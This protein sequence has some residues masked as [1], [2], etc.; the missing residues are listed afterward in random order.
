[1]KSKM[2][3]MKVN[4]YENDAKLWTT[5]WIEKYANMSGSLGR[6]QTMAPPKRE[7]EELVKKERRDL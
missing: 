4:L 7:E 3:N 2:K 6:K 1:M 5:S